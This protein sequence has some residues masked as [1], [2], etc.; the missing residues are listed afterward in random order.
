MDKCL[1][2]VG[3]TSIIIILSALIVFSVFGISNHELTPCENEQGHF[4]D[5]GGNGYC[6]AEELVNDYNTAGVL[7][8]NDFRKQ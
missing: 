6:I 2:F 8:N 4:I 1:R 3:I 5:E 7:E